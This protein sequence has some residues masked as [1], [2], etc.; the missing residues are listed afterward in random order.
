MGLFE[1]HRW[2]TLTMIN[3]V[4]DYRC[5]LL[6]AIEKK[7]GHSILAMKANET[8]EPPPVGVVKINTDVSLASLGFRGLGAIMCDHL[9][10]VVALA[11]AKMVGN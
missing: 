3:Y 9:G 11:C 7:Q 5:T 10:G 6:E 8:W 2:D 4:V 1:A